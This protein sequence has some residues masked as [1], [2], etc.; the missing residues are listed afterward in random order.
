MGFSDVIDNSLTMSSQGLGDLMIST[1]CIRATI[2]VAIET[3]NADTRRNRMIESSCTLPV[4]HIGEI[5]KV[6]S[7]STV[8]T[9]N[10]ASQ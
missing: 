9:R 2:V 10:N 1:E 3:N 8:A 6:K 7:D 4:I 5:I